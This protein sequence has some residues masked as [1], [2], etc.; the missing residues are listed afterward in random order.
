MQE[1]L[2]ELSVGETLEVGQYSVTIVAI[3]GDELCLEIYE[4]GQEAELESIPEDLNMMF[5]H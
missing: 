1:R 3:N 4:D 2:I 5:A